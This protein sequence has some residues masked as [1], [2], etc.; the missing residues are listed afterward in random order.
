MITPHQLDLWASNMSELYNSLE[1]EIIRIIAKRLN[2]GSNDIT[3][4][5]AQKLQ[6]L[7]LFNNEVTKQLQQV[8]GVAESE[9][10]NMFEE[11]GKRMVDDID[12]AM[13]YATRAMPTHLDDVMRGYYE[14]SWSEIDNLVN[15][16]LITTYHGLSQAQRSYQGVLN[17]TVALLSTG[18]YSFEDSLEKAIIELALK[19]IGSGMVDRGG[20][21]WSLE[22]Y[23]RTV[24]RSTLA[25]S[26][27]KVRKERMSEYGVHTVVV[28]SHAGARDACSTIQGN[29]VDLRFPE[30]LPSDSE[31]RSIYD[32]Y[33]G[34]SY[35][36]AGGHRGVNCRHNHIP[37]IPGVNTNNQPSFD[38][39]EL[40]ERLAKA[41]DKQRRIEREIVKYKKNLMVAEELG[42]S[43][44][45]HWRQMIRKRQKAMRDHLETN[46]EYL[47][48]NYRRERVYTPLETLL[49]EYKKD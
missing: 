45:N 40:N 28:T 25:N 6:E 20:H 10:R 9:I 22:G 1:G 26:Y 15:Q 41:R 13:P 47:R 21:R 43:S 32:I 17:R 19:G 14:Q 39:D 34:A 23:T 7:H 12:K 24:L 27:D 44:A 3:Q 29:V 33:W 8:T 37:F 16:T 31:Y 48:R 30:Q 11:A 35:G 5:Q 38:N 18:L 49:N 42:N 2:N 4:W 36:S 46:G